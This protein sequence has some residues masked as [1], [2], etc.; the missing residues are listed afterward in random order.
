MPDPAQAPPVAGGPPPE[1]TATAPPSPEEVV[2]EYG[3]W[4]YNLARRML[5]N[6]ADA[7]DVTQDVLLQ[8][9][10]GL[11]TFRGEATFSTWLYRVAVNA[12]LG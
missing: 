9:V 7:E 10:R 1:P 8:V 6:E 11:P 3:P 5:G 12:A 4:I 2:R